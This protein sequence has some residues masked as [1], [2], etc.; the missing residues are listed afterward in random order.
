MGDEYHIL[1]EC[2]YVY[3]VNTRKQFLQ[4]YYKRKPSVYILITPMTNVSSSKKLA[5]KLANFVQ[6]SK[7][8]EV[9]MG[10]TLGLLMFVL[11]SIFEL[12]TIIGVTH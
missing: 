9:P 2:T 7:V 3:I 6:G 10:S 4:L 12:D 11:I 1:F 5:V 8:I